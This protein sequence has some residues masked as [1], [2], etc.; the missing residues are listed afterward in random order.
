MKV[1]KMIKKPPRTRT[2]N[3]SDTEEE[4]LMRCILKRINII[5]CKRVDSA[6]LKEKKRIWIEIANEFNS[7]CPN[8]S[9]NSK[10]LKDK[11]TNIKTMLRKEYAAEKEKLNVMEIPDW[12]PRNPRMF[13]VSKYIS[14]SKQSNTSTFDDDEEDDGADDEG[15]L[16][17]P[18]PEDVKPLFLEYSDYSENPPNPMNIP[19]IQ[20]HEYDIADTEQSTSESWSQHKPSVPRKSNKHQF[21]RPPSTTSSS[22]NSGDKDDTLKH[23]KIKLI[24]RQLEMREIEHEA[25]L[26]QQRK[27]HEARMGLLKAQK[28]DYE[29]KIKLRQIKIAKL[30]NDKVVVKTE[31]D[32]DF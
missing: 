6:I 13:Q 26:S 14:L 29:T 10:V 7:L 5:E 15:S 27:E 3:F 9:R 18:E 23:L 28:A 21:K 12:R 24:E 31:I 22:N 11:Y 4:I 19:T 17:M 2:S 1:N 20:F 25:R 30:T 8:N 16:T 32:S